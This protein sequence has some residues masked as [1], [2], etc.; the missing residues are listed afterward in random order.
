MG[1]ETRINAIDAEIIEAWQNTHGWSNIQ[2]VRTGRARKYQALAIPQGDIN[3]SQ[4]N[5]PAWNAADYTLPAGNFSTPY[6]N[7]QNTGIND[8]LIMGYGETTILN[9]YNQN[10]P[11]A[12]F[13]AVV[14]PV[15]IRYESGGSTYTRAIVNR[16]TP[17]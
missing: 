11:F 5:G 12:T 3:A 1:T 10:L 7:N 16:V 6:Y 9:N 13:Y 15:I 8:M 17:S 14:D 2:V 4:N